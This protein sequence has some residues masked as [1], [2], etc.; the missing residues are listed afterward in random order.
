MSSVPPIYILMSNE[1]KLELKAKD[2]SMALRLIV[3]RNVPSSFPSP[4]YPKKFNPYSFESA[5]DG[6]LQQ[7]QANFF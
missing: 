4:G 3:E 1:K 5:R 6:I 2:P 7:L